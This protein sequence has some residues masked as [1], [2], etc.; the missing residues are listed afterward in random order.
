[1][2]MNGEEVN[3]T[4]LTDI[5]NPPVENEAISES[6]QIEKHIMSSASSHHKMERRRGE[7]PPDVLKKS[8]SLSQRNGV[9]V[10]ARHLIKPGQEALFEAWIQEIS[11]LQQ[12][13]YPGYAGV[14]VVRPTCCK[15]RNEYVSI[16]RYKNYDL[17]Q[18]FMNSDDRKRL[19][20]KTCDFE[21]A[22]IELTYHSLE[23]WFMDGKNN[24]ENEDPDLTKSPGP[25][26]PPSKPKMVVV[27]FLLI[28]LQAHFFGPALGNLA[29]RLPPLAIE[30]LTI[31]IIVLGT[32]YLWMPLVTQYLLHWWLFPKVRKY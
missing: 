27:T 13:K 2:P 32:T 7:I 4:I 23:Y 26:R 28:W 8:P 14:Q 9:T 1:M 11:E 21:A 5:E 29:P 16:F 17:L 12:E 22:P 19:L 18:A 15:Q 6:T 10:F 31:F 3:A 25:V 20:E 30:A 24:L